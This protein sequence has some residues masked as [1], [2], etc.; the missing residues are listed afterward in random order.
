MMFEKRQKMI[1]YLR[2]L[3]SLS[4]YP[5]TMQNEVSIDI[6]SMC[7]VDFHII[8]TTLHNY[9]LDQSYFAFCSTNEKGKKRQKK[10]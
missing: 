7:H 9:L 6:Y 2:N 3:Y 8:N 5:T 10:V 1:S 4:K